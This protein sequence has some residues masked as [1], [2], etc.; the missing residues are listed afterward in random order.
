MNTFSSSANITFTSAVT[1]ITNTIC[2]ELTLDS[3]DEELNNIEQ[4]ALTIVQWI[5]QLRRIRYL[6]SQHQ[7]HCK[8]LYSLFMNYVLPCGK[9]YKDT[10]I[11]DVYE[12]SAYYVDNEQ[13]VY[14][15]YRQISDSK[16]ECY[17]SVDDIIVC[18]NNE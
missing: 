4:Q 15:R 1:P 11:R 12:S 7:H 13:N 3:S 14:I 8:K 6:T 17:V 16:E 5:Q 18:G 10:C 9:I 2:N